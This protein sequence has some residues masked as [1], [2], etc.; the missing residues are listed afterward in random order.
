MSPMKKLLE[1]SGY[2]EAEIR[3]M[4][5]DASKND[6]GFGFNLNDIGLDDTKK[7]SFNKTIEFLVGTFGMG[8]FG[9]GLKKH[10]VIDLEKA[11]IIEPSGLAV[12]CINNACSVANL[13]FNSKFGVSVVPDFVV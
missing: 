12:A 7:S 2:N 8:S 11:G 3:M 4:V 1:N 9:T 5:S 6:Y 10:E 13:L